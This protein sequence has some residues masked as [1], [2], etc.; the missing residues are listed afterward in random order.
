M[1]AGS[2]DDDSS[3]KICGRLSLLP[4]PSS[5]SGGEHNCATSSPSTD[6]DDT[7]AVMKGAPSPTVPHLKVA[8]NTRRQCFTCTHE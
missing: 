3:S 2:N 4:Q 5:E 6:T 7:T 8:V 1:T